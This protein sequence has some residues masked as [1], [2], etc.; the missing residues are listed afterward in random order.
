MKEKMTDKA[1]QLAGQWAMDVA[2]C[3]CTVPFARRRATAESSD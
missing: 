1:P 2:C 3:L